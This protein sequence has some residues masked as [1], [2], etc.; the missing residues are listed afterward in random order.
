MFGPFLSVCF[1]WSQRTTHRTRA[2]ASVWKAHAVTSQRRLVTNAVATSQ[3]RLVTDAVAT[4][5]KRLATDALITSQK[6]VVVNA[7]ALANGSDRAEAAPAARDAA[8]DHPAHVRR[9]D[10]PLLP[11]V[12]PAALAIAKAEHTRGGKSIS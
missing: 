12:Q 1:C 5:R 4:S 6:R 10:R 11:E 2:T 7:A 9:E 3:K 8:L